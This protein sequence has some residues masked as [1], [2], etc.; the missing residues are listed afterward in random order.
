MIGI[1]TTLGIILNYLAIGKVR[2]RKWK[3]EM[4]QLYFDIEAV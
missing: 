4:I 1:T 3:G 2:G